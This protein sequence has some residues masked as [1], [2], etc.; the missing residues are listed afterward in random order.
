MQLDHLAAN[1]KSRLSRLARHRLAD[2]RA[3][4]FAHLATLLADEELR[5]VLLVRAAAADKSIEAV[6]PVHQPMRHEKFQRSVDGGGSHGF[7]AVT[8]P[9]QQVIGFYGFVAVPDQ[10]EHA[11][12]HIG[13]TGA[14]LAALRSDVP[15][16]GPDRFLSPE[17]AA[18][19]ELLR[20]GTVLA[21]IEEAIG[22]LA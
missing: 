10:F 5:I 19:E 14:A 6:D 13:E 15:G 12:A 2:H 21:A 9:V 8:Q 11:P 20:S 3:I 17:L 7:L 1:V 22:P 4:H 16:P 18:A